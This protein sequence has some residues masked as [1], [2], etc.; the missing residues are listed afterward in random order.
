MKK[1]EILS[2]NFGGFIRKTDKEAYKQL[3]LKI[4]K[5]EDEFLKDKKN[6][7]EALIYELGN[8]EYAYT[9][10]VTD[11]LSCLN[12]KWETMTEEQ[13]EVFEK[14]ESKYIN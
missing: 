10:D 11:T 4:E 8:H 5:Q 12:L 6:L 1:E 7:F 13:K 14:A 9:H 2:T 3:W